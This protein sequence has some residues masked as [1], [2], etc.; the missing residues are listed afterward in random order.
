[1]TQSYTVEESED[2]T[3]DMTEET[4]NGGSW[5]GIRG[6]ST[7][8]VDAFGMEVEAKVAPMGVGG[9][10]SGT[11][12]VENAKEGNR[13]EEAVREWS[14]VNSASNEYGFTT[15]Q[16]RTIECSGEAQVPPGHKLDYV[17]SFERAQ[18][19]VVTMS[20]MR[21]EVCPWA[22]LP[23]ESKYM[24]LELVP[25][26]L[27][28]STITSCHAEFAAPV[29]LAN[30]MTCEEEQRESMMIGAPFV[31]NCQKKDPKKYDGCQCHNVDGLTSAVCM[32]VDALGD[33]LMKE[34]SA[35]MAASQRVVEGTDSWQFT[36][37]DMKC[38]GS[39]FSLATC[40]AF[41][42]KAEASE[43]AAPV[44]PETPTTQS[45]RDYVNLRGVLAAGVIILVALQL[46]LLRGR[47][48]VAAVVPT[49]GAEI[50]V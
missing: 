32:C 26:L 10:A 39:R 23:G 33:P 46:R 5:V 14:T 9:E 12:E 42:P 3:Q 48:R 50:K 30:V 43:S 1:M 36:C 21:L 19:T 18:R 41:K 25:G 15:S 31:P 8:T 6:M 13:G 16:S 22:V 45:W 28:E 29:Y 7:S 40:D 47:V 4:S 44:A 2:W 49:Y 17:L 20:R 35:K 27:T 24:Y 34:Y 11:A 37:C 38:P